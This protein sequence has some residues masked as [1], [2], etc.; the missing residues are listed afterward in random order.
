MYQMERTPEESPQAN[1]FNS[2]PP[3]VAGCF[4]NSKINSVTNLFL[5]IAVTYRSNNKIEILELMTLYVQAVS[6]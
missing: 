5:E 6:S 4:Y 2:F 3:Q 1:H